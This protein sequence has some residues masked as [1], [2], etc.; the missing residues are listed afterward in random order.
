VESGNISVEISE[1]VTPQADK[2][3]ELAIKSEEP[4]TGDSKSEE[5]KTKQKFT[6][7]KTNDELREVFGKDNMWK[8][9]VVDLGNAC[10][11]FK[12]FSTDV[13]TRE[14]R[15]PEV[16][17]GASYGTP[18]DIWSA[19]CIV[20]ELLTGDQLFKPKESR[21]FG[22][23]DDHLAL[24]IE[25][26]GEQKTQHLII[27]KYGK[28]FFDPN[29]DLKNIKKLKY[30]PLQQVLVEKYKLPAQDAKEISEFLLPMLFF[31]AQKRFTAVKCL[32]QP[33]IANVDV[34][35]FESIF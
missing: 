9:K 28:H 33:W 32:Q 2:I 16:I 12:H 18:I 15:A 23:D 25:L 7:P 3:V 27:G 30:W 8:L 14:Y 6:P 21:H 26:L 17:L 10:W 13:Q 1:V 31:N 24:I 29:G 22:K 11:V 19:A 5:K 20:F 35:N 4:K 34:N